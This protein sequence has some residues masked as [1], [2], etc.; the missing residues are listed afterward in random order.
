MQELEKTNIAL[1]NNVFTKQLVL[2]DKEI[3]K[4]DKETLK[5]DLEITL[6]QLKQAVLLHEM[7]QKG[8]VLQTQEE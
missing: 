3:I 8:I 5:L 1:E 6:L 2:L 7:Q 4:T